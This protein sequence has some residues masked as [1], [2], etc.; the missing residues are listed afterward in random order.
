M[1]FNNETR[2]KIKA[3]FKSDLGRAVLSDFKDI[4]VKNDN[5]PV[6]ASDGMLFSL[7]AT[8]TEGE[9]SMLKQLIK[10]G[11]SND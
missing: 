7:L 8:R 1:L 2:I 6:N 11:E 9:I 3:L 10:I 4:I 5:Y